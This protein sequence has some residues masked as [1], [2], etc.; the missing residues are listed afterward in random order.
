MEHESHQMKLAVVVIVL[1]ALYILLSRDL[2]SITI[3]GCP[4]NV[5]H[6]VMHSVY[7]LDFNS[8]HNVFN[9]SI[10]RR[11]NKMICCSR[12]S[13]LSQRNLLINI[14]G[15]LN[16]DSF[17]IFVEVVGS[18]TCKVVYPSHPHL[19]GKLEDPR[20]VLYNGEYIVSATEFVDW[21]YIFPTMY[22]YDT[23]YNFVR[24]VDYVK[25][26]YFG[27]SPIKTIQKNWCPFVHQGRVLSHTD[28]YPNWK[29]FQIDTNTGNML[30][31]VNYDTS[32]LFHVPKNAFLRCSTSWVRY[33]ATHY[34]CGLHSKTKGR[35]P[36][37]RS[38]LVLIDHQTLLP[39]A[40]TDYLCFEKK[41]NRIQFLSGIEC[42]DFYVYVAYGLDDAE[43][44]V[45]KIAKY[46]LCFQI[47]LSNGL[48]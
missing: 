12:V 4:R 1:L 42:D 3:G 23:N 38:C 48:S 32:K 26:D 8:F 30:K 19:N 24:R 11:E 18:D 35:I 20:F 6:P 14:N 36:S 40:Y 33:D 31:L 7:R 45:K 37:I 27:T 22:I 46:R 25:K 16:Y 34:I 15:K 13:T 10:L 47:I 29:V 39:T 44:C 17:L 28:S 21:R 9:P 2:L 41:H 43:I 5:K